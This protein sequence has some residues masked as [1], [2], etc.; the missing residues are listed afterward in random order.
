VTFVEQVLNWPY[1]VFWVP[2]L[3]FFAIVGSIFWLMR[4]EARLAMAPAAQ[5]DD[6]AVKPL[7]VHSPAEQRIAFRRQGNPVPIHVAA[8]DDKTNPETG[9]V[10]D[11]SV[12]GMRLALYHE[13]APGVVLSIRPVHA[14]NI[15]PWVDLEVRSCRISA[16]MSGQFEVGCQ[17]VKSPPYSI[18]LL[19]G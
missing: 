2:G 18:Q 9:C 17:Y 3:V 16:E 13:V 8:P 12:G 15:V 5:A 14:D 4:R 11:R 10:L 1:A 7:I 19:F 6:H